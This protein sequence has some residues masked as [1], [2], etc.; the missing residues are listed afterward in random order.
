MTTPI[1]YVNDVPHIGHAYTTIAADILARF[2]RQSGDNVFFLTGTDEHGNPAAQ[3]AAR[4]RLSPQQHVDEMVVKFKS[5]A[6]QV[7]ATNDFFI[8]TTDSEHCARVQEF[9]QHLHDKGDI[10]LKSYKGLYCSSCEAFYTESDLV[11]GKCPDHGTEP[12]LVEEENYFFRLSGYQQEIL[13][14]YDSHPDFIMPRSR[15]N[16]ARSFVAGGLEDISISRASLKWGVPI[17]WDESQVVYVWVDALLNYITALQYAT[18]EDLLT[19]FWPADYHLMAKDILKFHAVIWPA[20]LMAAGMELPRHLFIHGY[21][22]MGGEKMSKTRGNVLDPFQV[23]E[24]YGV[25]AF[26]FYCFREV[27]FGQD[28]VVSMEG[29]EN[30]YNSE[31]ANDLGNLLSRTVAMVGK[32]NGGVVPDEPGESGEIEAAAARLG[33]DYSQAMSVVDLTGA[34]EHIWVFVRRLNKYVED[35]APWKLARDPEKKAELE[36]VLY[37][38]VEGLRILAIHLHPFLPKTT[39]RMLAQLG[40]EP[41]FP[42]LVSSRA[43]WGMMPAGSEVSP[44]EPLFPKLD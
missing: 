42:E 9:I 33:S 27:N 30:R 35:S 44:G 2:H 24:K 32:F 7:E 8:R 19:R 10:Y 29:F 13:D 22:L 36:A 23:M 14:H 37:R 16:E 17:P 38:L 20:M 5:L 34:L 12:E 1:Y 3:A 4:R 25:D 15:F 26:R 28:G 21:L 41:G 43:G 6:E 31:L 11:D 18:G 39:L 40:L